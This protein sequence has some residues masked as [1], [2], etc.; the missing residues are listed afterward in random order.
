MHRNPVTYD[1]DLQSPANYGYELYTQ[2]NKIKGCLVRKIVE[3]V[4][5]QTNEQTD[6]RS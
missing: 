5:K 4:G 1:P 6:E 3:I 2:K